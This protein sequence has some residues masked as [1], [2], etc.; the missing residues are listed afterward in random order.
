[1]LG[2][3]LTVWPGLLTWA[4][5]IALIAGFSHMPALDDV[6]PL[7]RKRFVLAAVAFAIVVLTIVPL[8]AGMRGLMLDCP[9]L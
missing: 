9:Y 2:L 1:M 6:T 3:G 8:P 5:M 4:L 7:D